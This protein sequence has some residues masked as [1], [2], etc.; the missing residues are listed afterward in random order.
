MPAMGLK[1]GALARRVGVTVRTLH[2]YDRIGL[3]VPTART[4]AGHRL[5]GE[6]DVR[7]LAQ[8]MLLRGLGMSLHD[9]DRTLQRGARGHAMRDLLQRHVG[10]LRE[11]MKAESVLCARL[12]Q[13]L[14]R[15][16]HAAAMSPRTIFWT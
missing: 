11:R 8:V 12:E 9:I 3:V 16:I 5:Y 2:H 13:L 7:R 14:T 15:C 6:R 10:M 4:G 1:V